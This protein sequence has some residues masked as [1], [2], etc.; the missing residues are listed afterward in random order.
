V[1]D[2]APKKLTLEEALALMD[3]HTEEDAVKAADK[4]KKKIKKKE[5]VKDLIKE[6]AKQGL[7]GL[8]L[9]AQRQLKALDGEDFER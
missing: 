4:E 7:G 3:K 1:A 8:G 5:E 6:G 2:E 9:G